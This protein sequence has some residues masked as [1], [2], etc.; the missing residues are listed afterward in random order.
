M[1]TVKSLWSSTR[2][3]L[4]MKK[5]FIA[6]L[7][8]SFSFSLAVAQPRMLDRYNPVWHTQS[9]NSGESMP[10]GGGDLGMNVWVE[11]GDL[12]IY[13]SRGGTF[14]ENNAMLKLGRLRVHLDPNPLAGAEFRQELVLKDGYLRV[15][16][17]DGMLAADIKVWADVF[18]PA[19]HI[20]VKTSAKTKVTAVYESWRYKDLKSVG[21]E[22]N[23]NSWKWAP[24][25]PVITRKDS[26]AFSQQAL[27]FYHRNDSPNVFDVTV[28]QQAMDNLKTE[29]YNPLK[30]LIF[31]GKLLGENMVPAGT[32]DGKYMD[33]PYRGWRLQ[34]KSPVNRQRIDVVFNTQ[35]TATM[36]AWAD[37]LQIAGK[38]ALRNVHRS[39]KLSKKWWNRFWDRSYIFLNA[40]HSDTSSQVWQAGRNYQLFRYMLACNAYGKWP[41]KFNGGLF[42]YDPSAVDSTLRFTPDFR[43]WGG[44]THTAQNQRLVYWPMLKS[45]DFDMM[46]SQFAFYLRLQNNAN[47]RSVNYWRHKGASFPEQIENFGLSNPA[48]YNWK[49]PDNF[50][51]GVE[52]NKWLEYEWDTVLEFCGMMIAQRTYAG[53][54]IRR[55]LPFIESCLEFFDQH[56][57]HESI[58]RTGKPFD[59]DGKL[60]LF[61]GS[62][63]ETYKM[64]KN[65]NST[66]SALKVLLT[67][68]L[69]LPSTI[70]PDSK[71]VRWQE[72]LD[73]LPALSYRVVNG[74]KMLAPAE[75]WER[76]NNT[77]TPQLYPVYPWGL[78]GIGLPGL[79]TARNTYHFDP[80]ALKFRSHVGWKQDNIFAARLGLSGEAARLNVLKL[81]DSGRRFPAFWGPGFDWT[82][83]HNWGGSGMIGL[84][85]MLM[86]CVGD[87]IYLLPAAPANW[88]IQFKLHAKG[89]TIVELKYIAGKLTDLKVTPSSRK[90]DVIVG[91]KNE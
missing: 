49:R 87:K 57:Q 61:P 47:L 5:L 64:T 28:K 10:C 52:Y 48:E 19:M 70:L 13:M 25:S 77:E 21:K 20:E 55:F 80:D 75:S 50:D 83:D 78:F 12:L 29:L 67:D 73:R 90:K 15:R 68:L 6:I 62:A 44:G 24:P 56:Y 53:Q 85:E 22:N 1:V 66:V 42:T 16:G 81:K 89:Q 33:T 37:S 59:K 2:N 40:E 35:Q 23:A 45:G 32:V 63:A 46:N 43:N 18:N 39:A 11:N 17:R 69:Q 60:V 51:K 72:M 7:L 30:D 71:K 34:T 76:I 3:L 14:D 41:T 4:Y 38:E 27:V 31:G 8:T 84:Q 26:I 79:D 9:R 36:Q 74:H 88:N 91:I 54:D 65:A 58:Q 82:P 86:Q